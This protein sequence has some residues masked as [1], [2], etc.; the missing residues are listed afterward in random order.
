MRVALWLCCL[1]CASWLAADEVTLADGTVID[2][3]VLAEDAREV[4]VRIVQGGMTAERSW[5][6]A[7]VQRIVRGESPRQRTLKD[8]RSE[9]ERIAA[10]DAAAW[11]ALA[12]RA[13]RHG[14]PAMARQWAARA[15]AIDRHRGEA[16]TLLGRELVNGVWLR[17]HEA[18]AARGL[19]WHDG[20]WLAWEERERLRA[21]ELARRERQ[22]AAT[23]AAAEAAERRRS[24]APIASSGYDWPVSYRQR[25]VGPT[26]VIWWGGWPGYG[27]AQPWYPQVG[28][29]SNLRV[30]GGWGGLDWN[31]QLTW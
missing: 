9:A 15:V 27:Y 21:E 5:P 8:L 22:R 25:L 14:D 24:A 18:A 13:Q 7:E 6:R 11:T 10:R 29:G 12:V 20:R 1:L 26:R 30:T 2:G 23:L 17:P 28:G 3:E 31:L 4:R 16:Q 19:V